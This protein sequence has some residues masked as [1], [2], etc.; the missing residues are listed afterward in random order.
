MNIKYC[1]VTSV[2]ELIPVLHSLAC[3]Q[4]RF[5]VSNLRLTTIALV[6]LLDDCPAPAKR[7]WLKA[8]CSPLV[9]SYTRPLSLRSPFPIPPIYSIPFSSQ[10]ARARTCLGVPR[11]ASQ[12][13][14]SGQKG[15]GHGACLHEL[16]TYYIIY[17]TIG[18]TRTPQVPT[19]SAPCSNPPRVNVA[20]ANDDSGV[21]DP[22]FFLSLLYEFIFLPLHFLAAS[23]KLVPHYF[24]TFLRPAAAPACNKHH[25]MRGPS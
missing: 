21:P 11:R 12:V 25:N 10:S 1:L 18:R 4:S 23:Q 15:E 14:K 5:L 6:V 20:A 7:V 8:P 17:Y 16:Y 2:S 24:L 22:L 13:K 3:N 19:Q 9:A